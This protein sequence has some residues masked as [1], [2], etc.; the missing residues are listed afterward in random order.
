MVSSVAA[1]LGS[2]RGGAIPLVP[3]LDHGEKQQQQQ[4]EQAEID[5]GQ[6][7]AN[8]QPPTA[9]TPQ[10]KQPQQQ[11]KHQLETIK[12][13]IIQYSTN[14]QPKSHFTSPDLPTAQTHSQQELDEESKLVQTANEMLGEEY[15]GDFVR[16][17]QEEELERPCADMFDPALRVLGRGSFG[18]VSSTGKY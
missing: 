1:T 8:I 17:E 9:A 18:R 13:P 2:E 11:Q 16:E 15:A 3:N 5:K 10:H 14:I 6:S 7:S 12:T 4:L